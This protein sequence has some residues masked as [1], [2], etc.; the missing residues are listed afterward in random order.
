MLALTDH[1]LAEIGGG[2]TRHDA[3]VVTSVAEDEPIA[4]VGMACRYPG[5]VSSPED[6][7]R[8]V[9]DGVDAISGFPADR[10]WD[11]FLHDPD[12]DRPGSTYS[13]QGG[14]LH[15]AA[16]FDPGFFGISPREALSMDPQ[17]RL[18]LETA[19]EAIERAGIDPH[20]LRRSLTGAFIG[21]SYQDYSAGAGGAPDEGHMITGALSSILSGRISYLFGLE[22]PAVTLDTAC[23]SSL[24]A[25]HLACQSLRGGESSLALA[26]GVSIMSTPGAFV[27][28]S[29]QRALAADGRCKA[30]SDA[31]DGMTLAEGVGLVLLERLSDAQRNGHEV[32]AVVRGSSVNQDGESNGLTAPN[33][34]AQQRVIRQALANARLQ[35]SDVDVVEGHGTGTALGDPI[36][37]D[38][39]LAT[40]GQ[41]RERPLLLGSIKSN[42]GHTQMASGVAGVIKM[43]QAL[44]RDVLPRTLHVEQPSTK[45]DWVP[46][47]IELLAE[48]TAWPEVGRPR[49]AAVSS[50]GL[51][52]TNAHAILE[53]APEVE[54][55]DAE[56][57][58]P[59]GGTVPVL[60]SARAA[61]A[62]RQQAAR[63][64]ELLDDQPDAHLTDV[65]GALAT[66]RSTFEHRA[67]VIAEDRESLVRGLTALRDDQ[68]DTALVR[69]VSTRG[70]TAFLFSGQG[71]Q[72]LGMGR[73]LHERFPAFADAFDEV[74][75][76]LDSQSD[77]PLREV[78]WGEDA[79]LLNRTEFAQPALFA[80]EVALFRLVESLGVSP[81]QLAG[82]SVG[83]IAA[84]HVAGVFSLEDACALVSARASLMEALPAGGA[85]VAVQAGE[86]EVLPL[87]T[88]GVSIAAVNGPSSVVLSGVEDEVL[89]LAQRWESKRLKVSHA[90]HSSLMDPMLEDFRTVVEG[91]TFREPQIPLVVAGDVTSPEHWVR[92]VRDAVRF[93]DNVAQLAQRDV[94]AALEIGPDGTLSALA[95]EILGGDAVL[96]PALRSDRDE[97]PALL[98]SLA[99]LH[100]RGTGVDW[101]AFFDGSGAR[102]VDLPTYPFQH[103]RFWPEAAAPAGE[104]AETSVPLDEQFWDAV[105]RE[106]FAALAEWRRRH[107][108]SAVDSWRYCVTWRPV[109]TSATPTGR[110][111]VLHAPGQDANDLLDGLGVE[112]ARLEVAGTDRE[113]LAGALRDLDGSFTG[114][115]SLLA[116]ESDLHEG[117]TRTT[118]A[119]QALGDSGVEAPLW[120]ATR[121]A[122]A[123]DASDAGP[124]PERAAVW[125]LGRVIALEHPQRWGGLV[126]LPQQLDRNAVRRLAGVLAG[127][128]E[129]QVAVRPS[130]VYARRLVRSEIDDD[131]TTRGFRPGTALVTGGTG[132]LGAHVAR[133]LAEAGAEH[134][135]LVGTRGANAPGAAELA[136]ELGERVTI[137]ACDAADRD[138]LAALLAEHRVT[139]VFHAAGVVEDALVD[140]LTPESFANV[141]RAKA[142][143][144]HNLHEL[145]DDLDAFV[146]FS[147]TAGVIGAA[148]QGNY[149]AANAFLDAFAEMRRAQGLPA[150]SV[151]WGPW[152]GSGMAVDEG[153]EE[154]LR[155]GG[156]TPMPPKQ[157]IAALQRAIEH[158][159][160]S[161]AVADIDWSRFLPGLTHLRPAPL[162]GDLPE[163][164]RISTGARPT[165]EQQEPEPLRE[166]AGLPETD[167][168]RA[169]LD[170]LLAHVAGVLGHARPTDLDPDR[171]FRDLGFDSLTTLELRNRLAAAT[172]LTLPASLLF[173]HPT[174]VDLAEFLLGEV[175]G[176]AGNDPAVLTR[177]GAESVADEPIAIVGIGC[178][179]PGGISSPEELWRLLLDGEDTAGPF[180]DDR[181]WDLAALDAG[182]SATREASFLRGVADFDAG[183]FGISPREAMAMDPQQRLV[184][185]TAWE[186]LER[187]GI[188]PVSLRGSE[189]GVFVGTNG[190]DYEHV[191]RR[192]QDLDALG[193]LATGNTASVMSGRLAYALGLEGPAVTVDT[194]C[195]SSIVAMHWA[196]G[197]LSGGECSLALAGGVSVMSSP[198]SFVEFTAQD[199]LAPD[200]RC[201]AFADAADGTSWSEGVGVLV[202]ERLSDAT[203]NGHEVWGLL[204][205]SAVNSDGASN[206]LTAPNGPSQQRVIR[207]ALADAGLTSAD[208][209][210]IEA[211]GTGTTLGDPIE[212]QA[213]LAAFR[214]RDRPLWLGSVKSNLGHAQ[215]A[216]GVAG[217]IKMVM[218]MRRGVLPRTVHVD[219]PTSHIDWDSGALSLLTESVEWPETGRPRRSGVSA[220]GLSGTNA[221]VVLE[222]VPEG[223]ASIARREI[224]PAPWL[225]SGKT[226]AA[227]DA[228]I[229]RVRAAEGE[230]IDVA[231]S[232]ATS[233]SAFAHRAALMPADS[234]PVELAR[235]VV[236]RGGASAFLFSGQGAQRLGMGRELSER[237]PVFA[238]A[239]DAVLLHLDPQLREVMWGEDAEALNQT[240]FAQPALFAVEVALFRLV[241]WLGIAPD[242]L[243]GHSVGEIAAAHVAGVLSLEDACAL[244]SARA[245][246]MQALPEGGAMV[247]V[248]AAEAEVLPLLTE[249]VSIAA[250]NGP[251]SVVLSGVEDEVLELAQRWES[252]RLKVSHAFHSSLMDPMLEDFRA[253]VER[254]TFHQPTIRLATGGD[255]TSPEHWVRHVRDTV[256]FADD[257]D[258][259]RDAGATRFVEIG[260][261]G[262][263][264]ALVEGS[265]PLLR[266]DRDEQQAFASALGRLFTEGHDVRWE[267]FF[268][269]TGARRIHLP[270]YAFQRQ[271]YWPDT[272]AGAVV[273]HPGAQNW[274]YTTTWTPVTGTGLPRGTWLALVPT[275][276][277][278][279]AD[280]ADALGDAVV[281][282][283]AIGEAPAQ[284]FAGVVSLLGTGPDEL[285]EALAD[286]GITAPLWCVT[287]G[288]VAVADEPLRDTAHA[289]VW[290]AGQVAALEHA[291]RWGGLID[292]PEV[293]D[294]WLGQIPDGENE[295]AIRPDGAHARRLV[296]GAA[297][298]ETWTPRGTVLVVGGTGPMGELVAR[299]LTDNGADNLVLTGTE[300]ASEVVRDLPATVA[301]CDTADRDGLAA[302]LDGVDDLTAVVHAGEEH[303]EDPEHAM[304][305]LAHLDELL[306]DRELDA[307]VVLGSIAGTW[308]VRGR[309]RQAAHDARLDA[310]ARRRQSRGRPTRFVA[311]GPWAETTDRST[312]SH[313][314]LSGL[315]AVPAQRALTVLGRVVAGGETAVAVADVRWETFAGSL[316]ERAALFSGIP[317]ARAVQ[318][319]ESSEDPA[320]RQELLA[321]PEGRRR[322]AVL[323]LVRERA[324]AVLGHGDA[325]AVELDAPFRDLGFDSLTAV[326]LRNQLT[327]ATGLALTATLVFD[328]PTP[329][330]LAEHLLAELTGESDAPAVLPAGPAADEPIAIV[331]MSCRYPGGVR[332]PED[333][334]RLLVDEVDAVGEMPT[335][336]GWDLGALFDEGRSATRCGG[337]LHDVADFD[338]DFFSISPREALVMD[339]QQRLVLEAAWESLERAGIDPGR[340]R[341]SVTGVFVGGGSGEY[342]APAEITGME[343]QTAQ[344]ASLLSGRVAYAF[345][346]QGPT[347]S[348]DTACSSS[349]VSLHLAA[350]ALRSGECSMALAGGVTVMATPVGFVEFSAQG[351]LSRDGRC[352][353]FSD[354]ADGT[355]WSEG[356]GM[357]VLE[358]LSD[359]ERNGHQVLAVVR[360]S[361]INSDGASNG[362][363]APSGPAQQ[364]VIRQALNAAGLEPSDVDAVEAHG[365]GTELGDPIEAQGLLATYGQ[366]RERPLWLG[367]VKSNIGHTQAASGVAGVIKMVMAMRH[368]E[369]PRTLHA[370]APSSH[371]D[372]ESGALSLLTERTGWPETGAQRRAAVSSFGASG[373]NAHVILE[374]HVPQPEEDGG[375]AA[376]PVAEV[377]VPVSG[378]TPAALREQARN[379]LAHVRSGAF[380]LTDIAWSA[381]TTRAAFEQRAGVLATDHAAL[382]DGL[383]ALVDDRSAPGVLRGEAARHRKPAFLFSGQGAQRVGM[384]R[385]LHARFPAFADALDEVLAHLDP[386]LREVMWGE[387]AEVLNRT[388]FTQPALFAVEVALFR[389]VEWL[390]VEP[391]HLVGHSVGE[392]AAAHVAGVLSLG[393]A[394]R[395]VTARASL[396]QALPEGGAMVAVQAAEADVLPLL[397]DGVSIAAVNGA[398]SVVLS[399]VESEVLELAQRW[400]PKRLSVSHAFHSSL[401]DPVL[402]DF[403]AVVAELTFHEPRIPLAA[404]GDVTSPERWV[405][406]VRDTVRFADN[407]DEVRESGVTGFVEIG[408]DGPLSAL[409]EGTVP[410]LRRDRDE[411]AWFTSSLGRLFVDGATVDW[412]AFFDG[413]GAR[414]IDLP[415]YAFQRQRYWPDAM[416]R[417]TAAAAAHD[418][419]DH[420]FWD[421]VER[422]DFPSLE[423]V[424]QVDGTALSQVLP[425]LLDWRKQHQDL[426]EVDRWRHRIAWRPLGGAHAGEPAGTWLVIVP[427]EAD[428][429]VTAAVD[430]L[431]TDTVL[432]EVGDP[433]RDALAEALRSCGT[434]FDG[435]VSLLALASPSGGSVPDGALLTAALIQAL[436]DAR[437]TAPLWCVTRRGVSTGASDRLDDVTQ[438]AV[439]GLGRVAAMEHPE[440]WGGLVDLPGELGDGAAALFRAVLSGVDGE[441]QVAVRSGGLFAR[442]LV[443]APAPASEQ[444]PAA[445]WQPSGTVLITGGTGALGGHVAR[446]LAREGAEHLV[447][448]SRRGP[449][450]P[451]AEQL[452]E[453]LRAAGVGV[454]IAACD[455]A[456]RASLTA[457]LA[458]I[459]GPLTGVVHTAGVIDDGVLDR[460]T[461]ERF[462]EV[463]RTKVDSALLLDELTSDLTAFVLFSSAS[464]AV[465]S[466]GQANYAAANAML[467]ALAERRRSRGLPATSIAW[468]AWGGGGMAGSAEAE[469]SAQRAGII[470]MDPALACTALRQLAAESGPTAVVT[471]VDTGRAGR[472]ARPSP[473][474]RELIP[475]DTPEASGPQEPALP[476]QIRALAPER[477]SDVVLELVRTLSA[478]VLGQQDVEVVRPDR[479]FRDLGFDSLAV[480]ELRNQLGAATGLSLASTLVFDHPTPADLAEH[481]LGELLPDSATPATRA[482]DEEAEIRRLLG[483]VPLSQ[484]REI[485][486]LE[487]LLQLVG[488]DGETSGGDETAHDDGIDE[489]S[490]DDLVQAALD[491]QD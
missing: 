374:Q 35:P 483:K 326:D 180:P 166:L 489:M 480:V 61:R 371:V 423:N 105:E 278:W 479:P 156:F 337:F 382:I 428:E 29:R 300:K 449:D 75:A 353:A 435:V 50:F 3:P 110:W 427:R 320:M 130:G 367:A 231:C 57:R 331:G 322:S 287:R 150:T 13:V 66:A 319:G 77:R 193:Y 303:A 254:L 81:D 410:V 484:L 429:Q 192:S 441:D 402:E 175:V 217:V 112:T 308:G 364:R 342:R 62:L 464:S 194:A 298:G 95:Q 155:R 159:D 26:G 409:V 289:H 27:G 332:S 454:T 270:T 185:E 358:R 7:W 373:T 73:E 41:G 132:A 38:A 466:P 89:E 293:V 12:P 78:I 123:A 296:R 471:A 255:V 330:E 406:H 292:L 178:R 345:G 109:T 475:D 76:H 418:A 363:T 48:E 301:L 151:A 25:L 474:M 144:A 310:F 143:A 436:G 135:L 97:V 30:Y 234:G 391:D 249:G 394:C 195:S 205:G 286:A 405:R 198:D 45:V 348:V 129:D 170:L 176:T 390:G 259:V 459:P 134:L 347:V 473:L 253:V 424:L 142:T 328:H 87:L 140:S 103:E 368:G 482:D 184:L 316:G 32:L 188:D 100:V 361:A 167:R 124:A 395:L 221:H 420:A 351:A 242:H 213:L 334:W 336:R 2:E 165:A 340:L 369:L 447:L 476:E 324:A 229:E 18:L 416:S 283:E 238:D 341:G 299:W 189:T 327:G 60:V 284:E 366:D 158:G 186:A 119:A 314:R 240:G 338:P 206:G 49:R 304:T 223:E 5:G 266:R 74:C 399:G 230:A 285:L 357:L 53:Q 451:G 265:V 148:G 365:T 43:V 260:P 329:T 183:F 115:L 86:A 307:F 68:P 485:G 71:S 220:F 28:F 207:N 214:D 139:S 108:L 433:D 388:E 354:D 202:L 19:W 315:P 219:E 452:R 360:G 237:F 84:A 467:D 252:K 246:L 440:R 443:P 389:L 122:V 58:E 359:A 90:F 305:G 15:D 356:V 118:A 478:A 51:S 211:H 224:V 335:D 396:M 372:W 79:E 199:G 481:V 339:P 236:R 407:V 276:D 196:A 99:R 271:R 311:W 65:A 379:L 181:G 177:T 439:W 487:P 456:D 417:P 432:V 169:V 380:P 138:A 125:G 98:A 291:E 381:A 173:D 4:I 415:T 126:D 438:G 154:R 93:A 227:L 83:E 262:P 149:A 248:Q 233:R 247:A 393:D 37:A 172:G 208:V 82:H 163:V 313:L 131:Q 133:W 117:L 446:A 355:G 168:R 279:A 55:P 453:E 408:P 477:R 421:A 377:L 164:R 245:S 201:K 39:L 160:T 302:L 343:W 200:G 106:D 91:L 458:E 222:G 209:D 23:S 102:A 128:G 419:D 120:V 34:L 161:L 113:V 434:G 46:G 24:M 137:A 70:R 1:L 413:A 54:Q 376:I 33:G 22:G 114:V 349:L 425:A 88:G 59:V 94:R 258:A 306:G 210:A 52:G 457:L 275:G 400:K 460:L 362:L 10:G 269:G 422:E 40:Y 44:Q 490:V 182:A 11:G 398:Q 9:A 244:V 414:R 179:F 187:A 21:A 412:T 344:S 346:L 96:A 197:A 212:A 243:V 461:P 216:A 146:L 384:G 127:T 469:Q 107:Q 116:L 63:L 239:L 121:G 232:L 157:A 226:A 147:S 401:M 257:V 465:G 111:L 470:P 250:V 317:E 491:G 442:R 288:A 392:I 241:E 204:R 85:M 312:S 267:S 386:R 462:Q 190:Q 268:E 411:E 450:A 80:V 448:A 385:G 72:R 171:A 104:P 321:M 383:T 455:V 225:V 20:R 290:G 47:A 277:E 444:K 404:T 397:T 437:I 141:L 403:R 273:D 297:A 261:D 325:D 145:T 69:G 370:D 174:P 16:D 263:L 445:A 228:Q 215:A 350:Q 387:D 280:A 31:A 152:A 431:G 56:Q 295:I 272:V 235:G 92:H 153:V 281:R 486:V 375:N 318:A 378:R 323:T 463:F 256:R 294:D 282:A 67:A 218:A 42:I 251:D 430:A 264:S 6:L 17:Q 191:L 36:E 162:V 203:R 14:F 274:L 488:R 333:L 468:G 309:S 64:L 352:K 8:L 101:P 426:A 136:Q 472:P